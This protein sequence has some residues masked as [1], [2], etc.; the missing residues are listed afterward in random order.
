[1]RRAI[2]ILF[3]LALLRAP[4]LGNATPLAI[5]DGFSAHGRILA[6][7]REIVSL[8]LNTLYMSLLPADWATERVRTYHNIAR[9]RRAVAAHVSPSPC[10]A[11]ADP[12]WREGAR[13]F[14]AAY[15]REGPG[16]WGIPAH[17]GWEL[18]DWTLAMTFDDGPD[19][20]G[21][22]RVLATLRARRVPATFFL[23]GANMH[24]A[25]RDCDVPDY[26]GFG[27]GSHTWSHPNLTTLK[28]R[29]IREQMRRTDDEFA[30]WR[31][32]RPARF[33][34]PYGA[35]TRRELGAIRRPCILWN[36]DS[37]DYDAA[38]QARPGRIA[39]R[40]LALALLQRRGV[41]LC[42]D[43]EPQTPGLLPGLLDG[44]RAMGFDFRQ[45]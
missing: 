22:A 1:M 19:A 25:R 13:A 23:L 6:K 28:P 12:A 17:I 16:G 36:I 7:D 43:P 41:V 30:R 29:A 4:A 33:R 35:C 27:L 44:L 11:L 26:A 34:P 40:V 5:W 32:P 9:A 31:L 39:N 24:G 42:H 21:T 2:P 10:A 15:V 14:L 20:P 38:M 18:P 3:L 37:K 45:I 8:Y